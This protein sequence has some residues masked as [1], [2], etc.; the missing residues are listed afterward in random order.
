MFKKKLRFSF[1]K[2]LPKKSLVSESFVLRYQ[3]NP[4]SQGKIAVVV[5]KK[6]DRKAV[7][8]NGI[9]RKFLVILKKVLGEEFSR[10]MVFFLKKNSLEKTEEELKEEIENSVK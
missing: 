2:G 4:E 3:D 9:K 8:R 5:S 6:V 10:E 7:V 1:K